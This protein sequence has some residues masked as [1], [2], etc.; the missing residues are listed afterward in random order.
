MIWC[1]TKVEACHPKGLASDVGEASGPALNS[2]AHPN[3][4]GADLKIKIW[5]FWNKLRRR[6]PYMQWY[7]L[8]KWTNLCLSQSLISR[9]L[10]T[11]LNSTVW[12]IF[13]KDRAILLN[14]WKLTL[15][16]KN[17]RLLQMWKNV[18][19]WKILQCLALTRGRR[20]NTIAWG[21]QARSLYTKF[22]K[23]SHLIK[24]TTKKMKSTK[25]SKRSWA[26]KCWVIWWL[27]PLV[28]VK[29]LNVSKK[30]CLEPSKALCVRKRKF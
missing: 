15:A 3:C 17:I 6:N 7:L 29:S 22:K 4:L 12:T 30:E 28:Q 24:S 9:R 14:K 8:M 5:W 25:I 19:V 20:L 18:K 2:Q 10:T 1:K 13:H 26:N 16:S 21:R 23:V 11:V 27:L